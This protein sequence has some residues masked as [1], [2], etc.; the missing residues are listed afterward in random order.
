MMTHDKSVPYLEYVEGLKFHPL[1]RIVK[2][3]DLRHNSDLSR[4]DNVTQKDKERAEKYRKAISILEG[5]GNSYVA[6]YLDTMEIFRKGNYKKYG[7]TVQLKLSRDEMCAAKVI[8][9]SELSLFDHPDVGRNIYKT[10]VSCRNMDSF[11]MARDICSS[12]SF[13]INTD[14]M[15]VLNF[16]NPVNKGGGVKRGAR[17]QEEDLSR[18]SSLMLSLESKGAEE[19][20]LYNRSLRTYLGSDAMLLSPYV[21]II[22]DDRGELLDQTQVVSVLTCAAPYIASGLEGLTHEEYRDMLYHRIEA[23]LRC[24]AYYG[25]THLVLG[26]W[27][28]GAFCN[29]AELIASLFDKAIKDN[30]S[31]FKR[32]DFAVYDKSFD[33]YNYRSFSKYFGNYTGQ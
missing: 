11:S 13:G 15:L 18:K 9:P 29:D 4:I 19:Y 16:A 30:G 23:M 28:C 27:G 25:Y 5:G 21:E 20:Y 32:I 7:K 12:E 17:A 10:E 26:A 1:P 6:M 24:S 14:K 22:R 3:A 33:Q 2:L 8:L 31:Y